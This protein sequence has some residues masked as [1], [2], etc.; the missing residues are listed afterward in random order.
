M[1]IGFLKES[2]QIAHVLVAKAVVKILEDIEMQ[3]A[4][5]VSGG[6]IAFL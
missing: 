6:V 5:G 1:D 4:F 3:Y 2:Q